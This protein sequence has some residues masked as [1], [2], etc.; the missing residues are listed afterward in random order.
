MT[1]WETTTKNLGNTFGTMTSLTNINVVIFALRALLFYRD[2][3]GIA[4]HDPRRI[5]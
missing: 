3:L 1:P 4:L 5:L 2:W